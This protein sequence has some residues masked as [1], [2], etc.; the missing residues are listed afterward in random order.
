MSCNMRTIESWTGPTRRRRIELAAWIALSITAAWNAAAAQT[1]P[2]EIVAGHAATLR[3]P[4]EVQVSD[5]SASLV[6]GGAVR[7]AEL[8]APHAVR[9]V[10]GTT[11]RIWLGLDNGSV[12][13]L[14]EDATPPRLD[15][16]SPPSSG[17]TYRALTSLHAA[18]DKIYVIDRNQSVWVRD[19]ASGELLTSQP[20]FATSSTIVDL[21]AAD[22]TLYVAS[23][24][25]VLWIVDLS[26]PSTPNRLAQVT[27]EYVPR[28]LALIGQWLCIAH[29][30]GVSI[31]DV[32]VPSA[33][34]IGKSYRVPAGGV[35]DLAVTDSLVLAATGVH[36]MVVLEIGEDGIPRWRGSHQ[37]MGDIRR[38][39]ADATRA[40]AANVQGEVF[41]LDV[42]VPNLPGITHTLPAHGDIDGLALIGDM[43]AVASAQ[44]VHVWDVSFS[45]PRFAND[46]LN[47]GEGINFGGQRK[48]QVVGDR[49]YVADWF[50]GIH[51]YDVSLPRQPRL[52]SS[53]HTPGSPKGVVVKD[54]IAYIAD[55]DHGLQIVNVSNPRSPAFVASLQTEGLAY[56]PVIAEDGRLYLASHR[57]GFQIIDIARPD[58]PRLLAQVDT[59]GKAWSIAVAG[60]VAYVADSEAGLLIFDVRASSQPVLLGQ[61]NPGGNAEDVWIETD[62]AYVAFFDDGLYELDVSDAAAPRIRAHLSTPGNARGLEKVGQYLL[63]ADWFAGLHVVDVQEPGRPQLRASYDT[64]GAAWGVRV[65]GSEAFVFDWWGGLLVLDISDP[66]RP[67][68][69]ADYN[70][71]TQVRG[72]AARGR[73]L[74]AAQGEHG[75]QVFDVNNPLN[76]TWTT[77]LELG[78]FAHDVALAND[79]AL[80]AAGDAG[81]SVVDI[82][83]PFRPREI[84]TLRLPYG[85][86]Q[87]RFDQQTAVVIDERGGVAQVD[88][89]NSER[90]QLASY[91]S[92]GWRDAVLAN[93]T[94]YGITLTGNLV[95][96]HPGAPSSSWRAVSLDYDAAHI[97]G[98]S[99]WLAIAG[100]DKKLRFYE[101][102]VT[103]SGAASTLPLDAAVSALTAA[104]GTLFAA[105]A[106]GGV[107]M[108]DVSQ[109]HRVVVLGKYPARHVL[110]TLLSHDGR[111]YG[112]GSY[113]WAMMPL[114][115]IPSTLVA[116]KTVEFKLPPTLPEG[117][118]HLQLHGKDIDIRQENAVAVTSPLKRAP[119][120]RVGTP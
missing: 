44:A 90:A 42:S 114:P 120:S 47:A 21:Q 11:Q 29:E 58:A 22:N 6:P 43:V 18:G 51:I 12:A 84:D 35:H 96:G 60:D 107:V 8:P 118:Y 119:L 68:R 94:L 110:T 15:F 48:G 88:L 16:L 99:Q 70:Q 3:V 109:P 53:Y 86:V 80:I 26:H 67:R 56:T 92:L 37:A 23:A 36:G 93:N 73:Y 55:D 79:R 5:V 117:S 14:A 30:D 91:A 17:E 106:D 97:A 77:G 103:D 63:V 75:L 98:T 40:V 95:S 59:P 7:R 20:V 78:G 83:D 62:T 13:A 57:G 46:A 116:S 39:A 69:L 87:V 111:V 28:Q 105:M 74:F 71:S 25:G 32:S 102:S 65:A 45:P 54:D 82:S 33:P 10:S 115:R 4:L 41:V 31:V 100:D 76:P 85:A 72:M 112:G 34:R 50:S 24:D 2:R 101:T 27:F 19:A 52:L 66:L 64:P 81:L 61:F 104:G 9:G 89:H 38:I 49:L 1:P 113:L 108:M